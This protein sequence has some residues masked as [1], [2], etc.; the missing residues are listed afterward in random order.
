MDLSTKI[1]G[2]LRQ[3]LRQVREVVGQMVE[4]YFQDQ[5]ARSSAELAYYMLFTLF[6]LLIFA[7]V[8]ISSFD[9]SALDLVENL[10]M[11][12]PEQIVG[13]IAEYIAYIASLQPSTMLYAGFVLTL[14]FASRSINSLMLSIGTAYRQPRKG[15]ISFIFSMLVAGVL[16]ISIYLLLALILVSE[17]FLVL[18][19]RVTEISDSFIRPWNWLRF[20]VAPIYVFLIVTLFYKIAP[21]RWLRFRRAMPGGLFFVTVWSAISY[22][23]SYYV[24]NISNY[25]LLYG[26][27]GAIMILMLWFYITGIILIM[28]GHLNH[29]LLVRKQDKQ[30]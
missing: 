20:T 26:S 16:L 13:L 3:C 21:S 10:S 28:G 9:L 8:I 29:I 2:S 19:S 11:I 4:R 14:Y 17:N 22:F 15:K 27:L 7:N 6:P 30:H 23:F 5:V 25:S 24:S 18:L 12:L 1:F